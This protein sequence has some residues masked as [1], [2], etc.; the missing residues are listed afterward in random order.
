MNSGLFLPP[1]FKRAEVQSGSIVQH[2]AFCTFQVIRSNNTCQRHFFSDE[3][4]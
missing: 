1:P 2:N 3:V 4:F